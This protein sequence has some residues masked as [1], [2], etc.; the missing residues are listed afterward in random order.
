MDRC[1]LLAVGSPFFWQ[2]EHPPLAVGTYTAS[3][4]SLLAVRMPCAFYSQQ[5]LEAIHGND[6]KLDKDIIVVDQTCWTSIVKEARSLKGIGINVVDLIR[7]KLGNRDSSLFWEDKWYAGGVIKELFPRLYALELHKHAT[8][9]M[10]LMMPS[11]D[12]SFHRRVRSGAEES[13]FNS[14]LEIVQD[15]L[16]NGRIHLR[17]PTWPSES[18]NRKPSFYCDK[19]GIANVASRFKVILRIIDETRSTYI[20]FFNSYVHKLCDKNCVGDHGKTWIDPDA[21]Y[22]DVLDVMIG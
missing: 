17:N 3:G 10:K 21:Y 9:R 8:V 1:K 5:C 19:H 7:L 2:W 13:Q 11:L 20:L 6:G 15:V 22:P 18:K 4:N 16:K 14:L 12:N